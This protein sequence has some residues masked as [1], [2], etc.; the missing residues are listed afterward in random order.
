LRGLNDDNVGTQVG[1]HST[2]HCGWLTGEI[3]HTY[4]V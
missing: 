1:K 3:D 4:P 2:G